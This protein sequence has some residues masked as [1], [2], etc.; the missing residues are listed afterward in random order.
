MLNSIVIFI[1]KTI[2]IIDFELK[3]ELH[4]NNKVVYFQT[5]AYSTVSFVSAFN[6]S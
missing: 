2:S 3:I 6:W 1:I 5:A 4:F